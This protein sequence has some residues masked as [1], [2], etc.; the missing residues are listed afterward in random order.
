MT[1]QE[2]YKKLLELN[3]GN[4]KCSLI[5]HEKFSQKEFFSENAI[6]LQK[7]I[8]ARSSLKRKSKKK[9]VIALR[10]LWRTF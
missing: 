5:P 10:T 6:I 2:Y 8:S 7:N 9:S 1:E 4:L 3:V